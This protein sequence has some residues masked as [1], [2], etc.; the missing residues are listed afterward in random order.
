MKLQEQV[1]TYIT[2]RTNH[3]AEEIALV[4]CYGSYVTGNAT[5]L[6]DV[7]VFYIP[8]SKNHELSETF[9]L[10]GIGYD[11]FPL[12]WE[13]LE[14]IADFKNGLSPLLG[15]SRV[16]YSYSPQELQRFEDLQKQMQR[17]LA[18]KQLM[19]ERAIARLKKA[20]QLNQKIQ[21]TDSLSF[22]RELAGKQLS[23]LSESIAYQNQ[24]YFH[25][26]MKEQYQ[27]LQKMD[28]L[29]E[30]FLQGYQAILQAQTLP[31]LQQAAKKLFTS[32]CAFLHQP[33]ACYPEPVLT[34]GIP[35]S[36]PDYHQ[37]A[38][39]YEEVC[40][41]FNKIYSCE[42]TGNAALAFLTAGSLQNSLKEDLSIDLATTDLLSFYDFKDLT[43][44]SK[45]ARAIERDCEISII[46]GGG[47][48]HRYETVD[49]LYQRH[50]ISR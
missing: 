25:K 38:S 7:D 12:S 14:E 2:Q 27:E 9:I 40:S 48:I 39:W 34:S 17:Q 35:G 10:K 44:L 33:E 11:I 32:A 18:D 42:Q 16:I 26:G 4:V 43:R 1:L 30:D 23:S 36:K 8:R 3:L 47:T 22:A 50:G 45:Q 5:A 13:I 15:D 46:A 29:P 28:A 49:E 6:S 21:H 20:G 31:V 41:S 19:Q 37:A 24:T